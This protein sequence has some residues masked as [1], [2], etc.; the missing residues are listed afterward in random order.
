MNK[1][2][3]PWSVYKVGGMNSFIEIVEDGHSIG[4]I[5]GLS[6]SEAER[7]IK[8]RNACANIPNPEAIPEA[9]DALKHALV[10]M[11]FV[12]KSKDWDLNIEPLTNALAKLEGKA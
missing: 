3:K 6:L 4:Q 12:N 10:A 1:T 9:I 5:E 7:M 8:S 2:L 11:E